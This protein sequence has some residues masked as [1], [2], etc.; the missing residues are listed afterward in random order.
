MTIKTATITGI[1]L[2]DGEPFYIGTRLCLL[3][4]DNLIG[5]DVYSVTDYKSGMRLQ[6]PE[7]EFNTPEE[8]KSNATERDLKFYGM[9]YPLNPGI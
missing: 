8:A 9:S 4:K 6:R 7:Q 1:V 5:K 3:M 2:Q